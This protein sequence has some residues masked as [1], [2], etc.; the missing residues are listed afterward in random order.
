MERE[1]LLQ[2][3]AFCIVGR[4]PMILHL[5]HE[6]SNMH[7]RRLTERE[8][9]GYT[10]KDK[11]GVRAMVSLEPLS[12][13]HKKAQD[14]LEQYSLESVDLLFCRPLQFFRNQFQSYEA[15]G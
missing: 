10:R 8:Q 15:V 2:N 6:S 5:I 7:L 3:R 13:R 9:G 14:A 4:P 11:E 12:K 1:D